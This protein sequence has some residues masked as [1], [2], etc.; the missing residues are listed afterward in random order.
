MAT[1][2]VRG[3]RF[4][5]APRSWWRGLAVVGAIIVGVAGLATCRAPLNSKRALMRSARPPMVRVGIIEGEPGVAFRVSG[6]P[7]FRSVGNNFIVRGAGGGTWK[8]EVVKA[9]P[10]EMVYR[11]AVHTTRDRFRAEEELRQLEHHGLRGR[12]KTIDLNKQ[13]SL[14]YLKAKIYQV[15]I[16]REFG[17]EEQARLFQVSIRDKVDSEIVEEVVTEA[18]G[19]LRFTNLDNQ[20]SFDTRSPIRVQADR[21]HIDDI[22]VGSGFH[23][24]DRKQQRYDGVLE[25]RLDR[26]GR[27][28]V[29][30]ELDLEEY[31]KGVVPSEMP[32]T[33]P[34]EALR[35]QAVAARVEAFSKVGIRHPVDPFDVC[36]E[37]HC[38]AFSGSTQHSEATRRAVESTRGLVMVYRNKLISAF[39][40]AVCGGHT[41]NNDNVWLLEPQ[42]YLRGVLD[43]GNKAVRRLGSALRSEDNVR[44]WIDSTPDV[45]CNVLN[46]DSPYLQYSKRY[47]RWQVSYSRQELE[48]I[49]QKKTRQRF[50]NLLDLR[51]LKR[52]VSGRL[53]ELEVVGTRRRFTLS[54]ELP[55]RQALSETTLFSA[56]FYVEKQGPPRSPERFILKGAGWGH[57]VGMCQIGAAV[58]AEQGH[59]FDN[60]LKHYYQGV[61]LERL[62]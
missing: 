12:I 29:V 59:R 36:D 60:I 50:G 46:S 14:P 2:E 1:Q 25:I 55:I 26:Y 4:G 9:Q 28:T 37:V 11:L 20:Y 19:T 3:P 56:C 57:G 6:K 21:M 61:R 30:N 42:P 49:L 54:R 10:A 8:V 62:Y 27:I 43:S 35:A 41:E 7:I 38:Q 32:M 53:I 18:E 16:H 52:G 34:Q 45:Y 17:S 15:L 58:M 22:D 51:P 23:W 44:K 24:Q 40:C 39:Y 13:V 31:L 5:L 48:R 33:F 47:F